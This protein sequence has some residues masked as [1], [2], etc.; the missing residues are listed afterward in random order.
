MALRCNGNYPLVMKVSGKVT[1]VLKLVP[2]LRQ[3]SSTFSV[4]VGS[5]IVFT[6]SNIVYKCSLYCTI[7]FAVL[8]EEQKTLELFRSFNQLI[9]QKKYINCSDPS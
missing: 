7:A 5:Q 4:F 1:G 6:S 3:L 8:N 2:W 9:K